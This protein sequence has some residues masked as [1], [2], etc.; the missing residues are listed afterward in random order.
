MDRRR[1]TER[2]VRPS[3]VAGT[4]YPGS[5]RELRRTISGLLA[6]SA[7]PELRG[8]LL[9]L[10]APH[11]GYAYSGPTA[12]QAYTQLAG[13]SCDTVLIMSPSHQAFWREDFVVAA[14]T[15]YETPLGLVEVDEQ[16][17]DQLARRVGLGRVQR[18]DE[19]SLEI[20]L[21]FLQ[22]VLGDFR[23]VPVMISTDD[24]ASARRLGEV[25]GEMIQ[26]HEGST[27]L[28]ASTDL[29]H[30]RDYDE[31]VR[32]DQAVVDA[33]TGYDM[34]RIEA[35]LTERGCSVCG[36][37]PVLAVLEAARALGADHVQ[38]LHQ[39]T[40]GDVTGDRRPGQYTVGYL[41]AAV[42]ASG[43]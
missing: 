4:W 33:L 37:M 36:R 28:V 2:V 19:H 14:A 20:Q 16:F 39:T 42:V 12:A 29:H 25:L 13:K 8:R 21:P 26:L 22:V 15:H 31:V 41:A 38:V 9:G 34:Q 18:D 11:A 43:T 40:S 24:A 23:L 27:L 35:V 6:N 1:Q 5:E 17:V 7:R 3:A 30:I 10:I 32:R